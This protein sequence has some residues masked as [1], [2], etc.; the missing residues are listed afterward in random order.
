[1]PAV[2]AGARR[3]LATDGTSYEGLG[4]DAVFCV[5]GCDLLR[6]RSSGARGHRSWPG[7]QQYGRQSRV[8]RCC[9]TVHVQRGRFPPGAGGSVARRA[10]LAR[11]P[12]LVCWPDALVEPVAT[13]AGSTA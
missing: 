10:S 11:A 2:R 1:M 9:D 5:P 3:P 13:T 12:V 6:R 8:R 7:L 4:L